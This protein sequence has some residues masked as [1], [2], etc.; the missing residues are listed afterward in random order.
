MTQGSDLSKT[1]TKPGLL[2]SKEVAPMATNLLRGS[3][4]ANETEIV[5]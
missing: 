4:L 1:F 3:S 2:E 5:V